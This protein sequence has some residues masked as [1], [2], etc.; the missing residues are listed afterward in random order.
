MAPALAEQVQAG[1]E[2]RAPRCSGATR[3]ARHVAA[4]WLEQPKG[5]MRKG[6]GRVTQ[7]N[8]RTDGS[9]RSR[10]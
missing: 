4:Y 10:T 9:E 3:A 8:A 1:A 6:R 7:N 5:Q 2:H